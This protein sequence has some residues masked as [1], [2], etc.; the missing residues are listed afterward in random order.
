M[1]RQESVVNVNQ[2]KPIDI[3]SRT[4]S[5]ITQR[6][7]G[8]NA[9]PKASAKGPDPKE[10]NPVESGPPQV[11]IRRMSSVRTPAVKQ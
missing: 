5:A 11:A 3:T 9:Q 10:P 6:E 4:V 8:I 7:I 1:L 2:N